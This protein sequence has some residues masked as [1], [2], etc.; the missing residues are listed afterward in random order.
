MGEMVW[1]I[2]NGIAYFKTCL[3]LSLE[4]SPMI[5]DPGGGGEGNGEAQRGGEGDG[6]REFLAVCFALHIT[7]HG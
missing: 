7:A 3:D 2:C 4:G 6:V 5:P 1:L